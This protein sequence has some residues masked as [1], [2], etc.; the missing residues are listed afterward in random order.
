MGSE[1]LLCVGE[2]RLTW[3]RPRDAAEQREAILG[4]R[5]LRILGLNN[6]ET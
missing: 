3:R 1:E 2:R 5:L 6:A 4:K